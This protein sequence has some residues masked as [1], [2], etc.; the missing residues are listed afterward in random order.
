MKPN[1]IDNRVSLVFE[2]ICL[3]KMWQLNK[4]NQLPFKFTR[5]GRWWDKNTEID[6]VG[7]NEDTKEIVLAE[8]KYTNAKIGANLFYQLDQKGKEIP[9]NRNGRKEYYLLFSKSGFTP[10]LSSMAKERKDLKLISLLCN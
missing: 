6:I 4:N 7:L 10:E 2:D 9:W 3:H 8:C 5:V 1:F